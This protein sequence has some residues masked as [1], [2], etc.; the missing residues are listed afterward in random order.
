MLSKNRYQQMSRLPHMIGIGNNRQIPTVVIETESEDQGTFAGPRS[1]QKIVPG[2]ASHL[3]MDKN[4][5]LDSSLRINV[6]GE[7]QSQN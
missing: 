3:V 4:S 6:A 5:H 2:S 7:S 1:T